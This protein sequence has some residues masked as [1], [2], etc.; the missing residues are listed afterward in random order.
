MADEIEQLKRD[1][2]DFQLTVEEILFGMDNRL[3]KMSK[4]INLL[5]KNSE[6]FTT[7]LQKTSDEIKKVQNSMENGFELAF[8]KISDK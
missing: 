6:H 2:H 5:G 3:S 1:F 7:N 4:D 8:R